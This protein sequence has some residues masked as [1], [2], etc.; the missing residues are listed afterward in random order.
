MKLLAATLLSLLVCSE[1]M[2][3]L[4]L[5][6]KPRPL[7]HS[8][9]VTRDEGINI[10]LQ[11]NFVYAARFY[12]T[13]V[14][15]GTPHQEFLAVFDTA[16]NLSMV[17]SKDCGPDCQIYT[18]R[19]YDHSKSS[20]YV[21]D[22]RN[23][24]N[25]SYKGY[26]SQDTI[27]INGLA[28]KSQTFVEQVAHMDYVMDAVIG[29][30]YPTVT[31]QNVSGIFYNMVS[32]GL[33]EQP[34]FGFY[35][36]RRKNLANTTGA[37][38]EITLGG[39]DPTHFVG[40]LSY[41]PVVGEGYWQIK[42]DGLKI[43]GQI[44]EFCSGGCEVVLN[45]AMFPILVAP[46]ADKLNVQLGAFKDEEDVWC[47]N[48]SNFDSLPKMAFVIGGKDY[49]VA[50]EDY[51]GIGLLPPQFHRIPSMIYDANWL[52][53]HDGIRNKWNLGK[54]FIAKYYTEFDA[55]NKRVGFALAR[56]E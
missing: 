38:G 41:V 9:R 14:S 3:R 51:A 39:S 31:M 34:V 1:A 27:Y 54:L 44:S 16:S 43:G 53:P 28:V 48:T 25:E 11:L 33:V 46:D 20:T 8:Q 52:P 18:Y 40:Q 12:Y 37:Y 19:L 13:N 21:T 26:L 4:P 7:A 15:I 36:K 49:T 6:R 47:F 29:L 24:S 22:G 45:T 32:E 5:Y 56:N 50:P 2:I 23:V 55:G 42:M 35:F 30:G 17:Y 10:Y